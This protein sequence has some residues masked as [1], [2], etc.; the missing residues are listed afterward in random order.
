MFFFRKDIITIGSATLDVFIDADL[1]SIDFES[2]PSK[3]ALVLPLGEKLTANNLRI[4]TGGNALNAAVT[5]KRQGLS[6]LTAVKIAD[7][8]PGQV[9]IDKL[10]EEGISGSLVSLDEK[11][12]TSYSSIF[13][14]SGER[15]II[16]YKG[17]GGDLKLSDLDLNRMKSRFWYISLPGN[18]YKIFPELLK[19]ALEHDIKVAL[20]PTINHLKLG[21]DFLRKNLY[22]VDV[23]FV[24]ES[25]AAMLTGMESFNYKDAFRK[26]DELSPNFVVVTSGKKGSLI[27][28]GI[29]IYESAA[30]KEKKLVDRTGAGDAFASGFLAGIIRKKIDLDIPDERGLE[31]AIR[32][33]SANATSVVESVGATTGI[34]TRNDFESNRRWSKLKIKRIR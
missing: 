9:I 15:A 7:D 2:A 21:G 4:E 24:N 13:I 19:F 11:M 5:F 6:V 3:K 22:L 16:N 29:N 23:L 1:K 31:Y 26:L 33:A 34:L 32:L 14:K 8:V 25:E 18:S 20:N 12:G 27:S 28:D 17:A 10:D 30:F